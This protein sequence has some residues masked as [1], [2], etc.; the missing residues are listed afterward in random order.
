MKR[1]FIFTLLFPPLVLLVYAVSD[2]IF[3]RSLLAEIGFLI[4]VLGWAYAVAIIPAWLIAGLDWLLSGK[5]YIRIV[6]SSVAG[7]VL[8]LLIARYL[9]QKGEFMAFGLMGAI[10]AAVCSWLSNEKQN[11]RAQ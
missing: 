2:P 9:G 3:G 7:A 10:P 5:S 1:F 8:A 4:W 6:A 11:R